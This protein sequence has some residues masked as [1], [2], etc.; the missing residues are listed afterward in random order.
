MDCEPLSLLVHKRAGV[1]NK[2]IALQYRDYGKSEWVGVSWEEFSSFVMKC[3]WAMA[4]N[5]V[6]VQE[7]VGVFSQN[8]PE[9]LYVNFA[10]Y[11][12]RAVIVPFYATSSPKQ[13]EYMLK[14]AGIKVMFVGE[15]YQYDTIMSIAGECPDVEL[16]VIFDKAVKRKDDDKLSVYFDDYL[17]MPITERDKELVNERMHSAKEEDVIDILYTSGTTGEP[18]G[19]LLCQYNYTNAFINHDQRLPEVGLGDVSMD[20]LPLTH[21]FERAWTYYCFHRGVKVCVN[22]KPTDIQMTIKE[23]RPTL[24]CSVPRFW[25]KVYNGVLEKISETKGIKKRL[26]LDAIRVGRIHNLNYLRTGK[27]PPLG[28]RLKYRFYDRFIYSLLKRTVG[29]ENGKFF[30]TAGAAI[31]EKV[32]EF[33]RAVGIKII[34][35][36]GLT[37]STATVSF[38]ELEHYDIRS[39]GKIM[40]NLEVKIGDNDE[41]LLRGKTI[42]PGYYNK[43]EA[44]EAAFTPDGW[45]RT[46]DAGRIE[47]DILYIKDRLKD[48]FKTSNGKYIAPQALETSLV[49]D[50]FIDQIAIFADKRK[51]VSALVVPEYKAVEKYAAEHGIEYADMKDL[52]SKK[53][54]YDMFKE[55]ID[56]LQQPFAHFEQ[57]KRFTLMPEPFSLDKGELTNTLKIRRSVL[58][59]HYADIINKMYEE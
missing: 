27:T 59:K 9:L 47:G 13:V 2:R 57:I 56:G 50:P 58:N 4:V 34:A 39:V 21:I 29:I 37:E 10:A 1:F 18:K 41:I 46:G 52:L 43:P 5:G 45:F 22:L 40:P 12:N 24:M 35:G 28:I 11:A 38:T 25:E 42:T 6:A 23:I 3:A 8:K 48:L 44:N 16:V 15:Q 7:N 54:I 17:S 30:P 20:F 14:D 26:M 53:E 31:P 32:F 36:Y 19:V 55:R 33:A 49:I 51:Y